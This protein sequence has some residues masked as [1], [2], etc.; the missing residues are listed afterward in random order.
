MGSYYWI[1][2]ASRIHD[3][4]FNRATK[5]VGFSANE[6]PSQ[7]VGSIADPASRYRTG[8]TA[9]GYTCISAFASKSKQHVGP[10][11]DT[12]TAEYSDDDTTQVSYRS[13]G[14]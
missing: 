13:P 2:Y 5:Y 6:S 12:S 14:K 8:F 11:A 7:C 4:I 1:W 9:V 3:S 10:V